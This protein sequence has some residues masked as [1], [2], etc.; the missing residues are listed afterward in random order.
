MNPLF[1]FLIASLISTLHVA[2]APVG[3]CLHAYSPEAPVD[4]IECFEFE[5]VERVAADYRFFFN[6]DK[7]AL[8]TGYRFR[9]MIPYK[10]GLAPGNREFDNVLK[11]YEE[12]ARATPSTRPYLNPKI[13]AMRDLAKRN[14]EERQHAESLPRIV[15]AGQEYVTPLFKNIEGGKI[16]LSHRDGFL[17]TEIDKFSDQQLEILKKIDPKASGIKVLQV[18]G[19]RLWNPSCKGFSMGIIEIAHE[20]GV[21]S[22]DIDLISTADLKT[23]AQFDSEFGQITNIT[24]GNQKIWNPHY[25]GLSKGSVKIAHEKGILALDIDSMSAADFKTVIKLNSGFGKNTNTIVAGQ[26]LW[27][28]SYIGFSGGFVKIAHE[29]GTASL[30]ID[31]LS[32]DEFQKITKLDP[33]FGKVTKVTIAGKSLWNPSFDGISSTNVNVKHE[34]GI[35]SL[36]I[37]TLE[38]K[39]RNI[40]MSWSDGTWKI[41]R[42]GLYTPNLEANSYSEIILGNGKFYT[43]VTVTNREGESILVK[44]SKGKLR[45]PIQQLATLPGL[46]AQ[47][48]TKMQKWTTEIIEERIMRATPDV[49]TEMLSFKEADVINVSNIGARILQVLDEG[50]LASEF[51]GKL[52]KGTNTIQTTKTV[53]VEHPVTHERINRVVDSATRDDEVTEDV[54]DDLCYIVGNTSRLTDGQIVKI[55]S[56]KLLGRYQYVDVR[57]AKRSVRKYHVD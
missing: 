10:A 50:V 1:R 47:D 35:L 8:V 27:N 42:P 48:S 5:K 24:L 14:L 12:T 45:L 6:A 2:A 38:E 51:V 52:H 11:L 21:L 18:Y 57:G 40:I 49:A 3:I 9:G 33:K 23:I 53:N 44:T 13:L 37:E 46:S 34:K 55:D 4:K 29:K 15:I 7:S 54:R 36:E 19:S 31:L 25:E 20:N 22:L 28:P 39:D 41:G 32:E 56:M 43:D 30:D 17:K 16:I 26:K